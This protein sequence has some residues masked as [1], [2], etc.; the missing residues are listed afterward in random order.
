MKIKGNKNGSF[1]PYSGSNHIRSEVM[2][3]SRFMWWPEG[4]FSF[5]TEVREQKRVF[6]M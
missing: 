4:F 2:G 3:P 1:V 5:T 6:R